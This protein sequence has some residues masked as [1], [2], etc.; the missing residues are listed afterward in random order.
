MLILTA[1]LS[2]AFSIIVS[3]SNFELWGGF[4]WWQGI[5]AGLVTALVWHANSIIPRVFGLLGIFLL[6]AAAIGAGDNLSVESRAFFNGMSLMLPVGFAIS[7]W[8]RWDRFRPY[9]VDAAVRENQ[10][11]LLGLLGERRK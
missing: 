5:A 4:T 7:A 9:L 11:W 10:Q 1:L 8:W 6:F 3:V 2:A